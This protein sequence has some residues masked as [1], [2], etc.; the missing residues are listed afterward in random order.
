[1]PPKHPRFSKH[2]WLTMNTNVQTMTNQAAADTESPW[3]GTGAIGHRVKVDLSEFTEARVIIAVGI[4]GVAG[5]DGRIQYSTDDSTFAN[6]DGVNGPEVVISSTGTKD[7]GWF[8]LPA[9]ARR[10]VF[11]RCMFKDGDGVADPRVG[12]IAVEFR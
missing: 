3:I 4:A 2:L 11:L 10:D 9:A 12:T 6:L 8:G 5:A 7:S 1:M